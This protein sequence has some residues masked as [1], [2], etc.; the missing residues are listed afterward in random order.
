MILR[1]AIFV[2]ISTILTTASPLQRAGAQPSAPSAP[3]NPAADQATV[4]AIE[5]TLVEVIHH[6]EPSVVAVARSAPQ[7]QSL[8][9]PHA[10]D[11]FTDLRQQPVTGE[12]STVA[13]GVIIDAAGLVL[14]EYLAVREGEQNT[15]T[16]IDGKTYAATI[17]AA[18][19]RSGL[20]VLSIV[21]AADNKRFHAITFG[22]ASQLR[23]GQFVI[24]IG[25]PYAIR[26]DGEPTAS[27][28]IVTNLARKA[29]P[30]INLNDAPG[31]NNDYRTTLHHLGTLIQTDAKL[32]WSAG[33]GALVNLR[34]E[35]V[36][37]TTTVATIA[38]HEQPAG[39]AIPMDETIRRIIDTLKQGQEVEY[40]LLGIGFQTGNTA[41]TGTATA[42]AVVQQVYPGSPAARA[43]LQAGDVITQIAG[44]PVN[45]VDRLQ[46]LVSRLLPSQQV[47][48]DYLRGN[49]PAT[50]Q[51][52]L[53]KLAVPG[54]K[55]VTDR[56]P[57]WRGIRVDYALALD[58]ATLAEQLAAGALD[59]A[60]C[61]VVSDVAQNSSA[62][63]AGVRPG[64][65]ISHVGDQRVTTPGEFRD[66]VQNAD[67]NVNLRLT[68][69]IR[70]PNDGGGRDL[71]IP[72][73]QP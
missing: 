1:T 31:P 23:K 72:P 41:A 5:R 19:P 25:N 38:G 22:D 21:A 18:D 36:G 2:L 11:I 24:A 3:N 35:L 33:G 32:G 68:Q 64:M 34:G 37:L 28:G 4:A 8:L 27:W 9:A 47:T 56:P 15:I 58:A 55:V 50:A 66:A 61:V 70:S 39:Y 43:G 7:Q 29:P 63:N 20:A 73:T 67:E 26:S 52:S 60:G 48:I 12:P 44:Q 54:K 65:F 59:P 46:L 69:P 45:D 57:S 16:T 17:K 10:D 42:G 51:A 71:E 30:G 40:G 6:A 62:W 49:H 14:T 13:A 53:S